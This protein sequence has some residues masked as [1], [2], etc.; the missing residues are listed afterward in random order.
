[1]LL[2]GRLSEYPLSLLLDI[3]LYKRET[4]LL[5]ISCQSGPG[6]FYIKNGEIKSGEVGKLK[7]AAAVELAGRFVDASFQFKPLEPA[8]Y[9]QVV[10]EK[11]FGPNGVVA[12]TPAIRVEVFRKILDQFLSYPE[13]AYSILKRTAA[14]LAQR[15]LPQVLF[16]ARVAYGSLEK[17]SVATGRRALAFTKTSYE[18]AKR[19]QNRRKLLAIS[20]KAIAECGIARERSKEIILKCARALSFQGA[21]VLIRKRAGMLPSFQEVAQSDISFAMLMIALLV[22]TAVTMSKILPGNQDH[23]ETAATA[24]ENNGTQSQAARKHV[25]RGGAKRKLRIGRPGADR[26]R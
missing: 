17:A 11:S 22:G 25:S 15:A 4:G 14:L 2:K 7:G 1:M 3:F 18:L 26:K 5:E 8:D 6:Y 21:L 13:A 16:Y 24:D 10:W 20:R 12:D 23:F 9:A 19:P